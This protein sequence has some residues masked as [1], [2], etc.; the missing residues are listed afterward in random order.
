MQNKLKYIMNAIITKVQFMRKT[1]DG[2]I[3]Q[4]MP[5]FP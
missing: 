5:V 2:A 4:K 1:L 3:E